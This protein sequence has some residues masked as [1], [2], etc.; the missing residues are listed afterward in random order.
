MSEVRPDPQAVSRAFART[1]SGEDG[2]MVLAHLRRSVFE[3]F[4]GPE[5]SEAALR[6]QE[7]QRQLLATILAQIE[8]G[9]S[10]G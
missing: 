7:G 8:R 1:F 5:A 10:G 6:Q 4:L 3:R 2:Q 9:R